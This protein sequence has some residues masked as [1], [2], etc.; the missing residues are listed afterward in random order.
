MFQVG[1]IV[2]AKKYNKIKGIN[3]LIVGEDCECYKVSDVGNNTQA[4]I[5]KNNIDSFE[6]VLPKG[7]YNRRKLSIC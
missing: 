2:R 3:L 4:L 1:D 6:L 5:D 7:G